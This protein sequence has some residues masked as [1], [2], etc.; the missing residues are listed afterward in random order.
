MIRRVDSL[1][2]FLRRDINVMSK[3]PRGEDNVGVFFK[4]K[5]NGGLIL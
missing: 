2:W 5:P 3:G 1:G 4:V